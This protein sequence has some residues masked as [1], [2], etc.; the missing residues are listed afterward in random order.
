LIYDDGS[1]DHTGAVVESWRERTGCVRLLKGE[2]NRG[3]SFARNQMLQSLSP[4]TEY[5]VFLDSDDQLVPGRIEADLK[6]LADNPDADFTYGLLRLISHEKLQAQDFSDCEVVRGSSLSSAT[7]RREILDRVGL[8]DESFQQAEDTDYLLRVAELTQDFILHDDV[9]FNYRRHTE[10]VSDNRAQLR[11]GMMRAF[12]RHAQR[13]RLDPS[14]FD[15]NK[16]LGKDAQVLI[17]AKSE[18]EK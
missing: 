15:A 6:R 10:N 13:R 4:K 3:V 9:V 7:F 2:D 11:A 14:L 17:N 16:L 8:L 12:L 5:V 1:T 18:T